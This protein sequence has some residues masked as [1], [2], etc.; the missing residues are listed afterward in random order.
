[1]QMKNKKD[2]AN[3]R[4]LIFDDESDVGAVTKDAVSDF[5]Y[6]V[7]QCCDSKSAFLAL[8]KENIH[9][10]ILDIDIHESKN[11]VELIP[12]F[13]AL[14]PDLV[15]LMLTGKYDVK[16]AIRSMRAGVFDYI[17]KPFDFEYLEQRLAQAVQGI[18]AMELS[19]I[20]FSTII[21]DLKNPL[22]NIALVNDL[23]KQMPYYK[24]DT[25]YQ[26]ILRRSTQAV[27]EINKMVCNILNL[28]QHNTGEFKITTAPFRV[29]SAIEEAL[30]IFEPVSITEEERI[31]TQF[32]LGQDLQIQNDKDIFQH[33]LFNFVSNALRF[34]S[35][36]EMVG[37]SVLQDKNLLKVSVKNRGSFIKKEDQ[38]RIFDKFVQ[39]DKNT[40]AAMMNFG[41]GLSFCKVAVSCMGGSI[42]VE[43]DEEK[44]ETIFSFTIPL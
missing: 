19:K 39:L 35:S 22:Q 11:G 10:L 23:L 13:R 4:V 3:I 5:G 2:Q 29:Q 36:K 8:Q 41:L 33:V 44:N 31:K 9:I 25:K 27:M 28:E 34:S 17:L 14:N 6:S 24:E 38:E 40:S 32:D 37:V 7:T 43:S 15:I 1:M 16:F 21:H 42:F 18:R 26:R 20:Y 30:S 12:E